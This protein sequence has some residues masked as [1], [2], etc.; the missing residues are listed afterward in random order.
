MLFHRIE[1]HDDYLW[2][3]RKA[4]CSF[5]RIETPM[6]TCGRA[7]RP[8]TQRSTHTASQYG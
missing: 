2:E 7:V 6:T 8:D 3:G 5:I 4:R 1:A